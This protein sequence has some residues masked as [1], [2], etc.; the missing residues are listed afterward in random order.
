D[1]SNVA[2]S[3][4][5]AFDTR[6]IQSATV[7]S[8]DMNVSNYFGHTGSDGSDPG[9]RMTS[10]GF[11][12]TSYGESIAAGFATTPAALQGLIID[13]GVPDLGHRRHLLAIDSYFQTQEQVGVGIVLNGTGQYQNYFTIDS[14]SD[15]DTR[16][17]ITGVVFQSANN[18]YDIGE[19]M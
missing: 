16:P 13:N 19:G 3:Q 5:L 4:P 12:W 10:A 9:L 17:F 11:S 14:A 8:Q 1:L 15:G 6:L 7:H 2:P 18:T